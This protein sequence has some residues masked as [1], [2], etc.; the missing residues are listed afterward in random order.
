MAKKVKKTELTPEDIIKGLRSDIDVIN[1][2]YMAAYA[3]ET[4]YIDLQTVDSYQIMLQ[5]RQDLF[6][7]I[8][9]VYKLTLVAKTDSSVFKA[10]VSIE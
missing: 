9:Y 8:N 4:D 5:K 1:T 10:D 3:A 2:R 6:N 7:T